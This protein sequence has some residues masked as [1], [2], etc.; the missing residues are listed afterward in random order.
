MLFHGLGG[1][2]QDEEPFATG[3]LAPAGYAS[4]M[5]DARGHG[6]SGGLFGLD[7]PV[8][9]QDTRE[10]FAWLT[11][12]PEISDTQIGALGI[13]LGGGAVWNAVAA[14][15]P[16]KAIVPEITWTNLLTALAP[17]NLSKSGLVLLLAQLVPSAR[18]DP[19]AAR[20]GAVAR[21]EH[22]HRAGAR[23]RDARAPCSHASRRS[24]RR[25]SSS[26]AGT[27]SSSTSTRPRRRTRSLQA[28]SAL[29]IGDLGHSPAPNP[30]AEVPTYS[31]L[32]VKWFDRFLKGVPNGVDKRRGRRARARPV[33]REDDRVQ[34]IAADEDGHG[35]AAGNRDD[36]E[37]R[38]GRARR[39]Y[40]RRPA[41]DVRRHDG[42]GP[43]LRREELGPARRGPRGRGPGDADQRRRGQADRRRAERRR[44]GS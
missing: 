5:C 1:K 8:D 38:Q 7:G 10:L 44:S 32:A 42:H 33:G 43:L 14:G 41:R 28:R 4:L 18:W 20:R 26:R 16:F 23:A 15:I 31:A 40:H 39:T 24:R 36:P 27:T 21:P 12:R 17:E 6:A 29:Y 11:A 34:G 19:D 2:H 35:R 13:S 9:V 30:A 22:E 25:H 37:R 3:Y